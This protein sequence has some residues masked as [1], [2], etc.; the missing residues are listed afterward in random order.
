M[1]EVHSSNIFPTCAELREHVADRFDDRVTLVHCFADG[2]A[3]AW[4]SDMASLT[5]MR[6]TYARAS[7]FTW[8][9][10]PPE[11][12]RPDA[13]PLPRRRQVTSPPAAHRLVPSPRPRE[14]RPP[15]Q[16]ENG[17][18]AR[19]QTDATT[20]ALLPHMSPPSQIDLRARRT[21]SAE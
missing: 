8:R 14:A 15:R 12:G 18:V 3:C 2:R 10:M 5:M 21:V 4:C 13:P 20:S 1:Y 11:K 17:S 7:A 16:E 19:E 9:K 6:L